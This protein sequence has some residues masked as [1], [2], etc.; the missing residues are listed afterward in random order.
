MNNLEKGKHDTSTLKLGKNT[1]SLVNHMYSR[2][3]GAPEPKVGDWVTELM[4]TDRKAHQITKISEDG[5]TITLKDKYD[6]EFTIVFYR[7]KWRR[8][9]T[10]VLFEKG[11]VNDDLSNLKE[12]HQAYIDK[13]GQF[14]NDQWMRTEIPGLTKKHTRYPEFRCIFGVKDEYEDPHF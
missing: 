5:N 2:M 9:Y 7:G 13:G 11:V 12:I 4:W 8:P 3:A 14:I 10:Q 6:N 1:A